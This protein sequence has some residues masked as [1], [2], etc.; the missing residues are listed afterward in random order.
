M[1]IYLARHAETNYNLLKLCNS[2]PAVDVHLTDKGIA[3]A[4]NLSKT[5]YE[6]DFDSVY[7]SELPRTRQTAEIVNRSHNKAITVDAR[8]NDNQTGFEGKP[9]TKW[10]TA[11]R[12]SKDQ[13]TANFNGGE[14]LERTVERVTDFMNELIV[15]PYASVLIVTHGFITQAIF[16]YIEN[17]IRDEALEFQLPQGTYAEFEISPRN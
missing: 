3:Q 6:A 16:G 7:I 10:L 4:E 8:L 17:K 15:Q 5:L 14:S 12:A 2:D 13:W 11:L 9:V 1:K